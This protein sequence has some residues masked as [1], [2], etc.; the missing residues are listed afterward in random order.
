MRVTVIGAGSWGTALAIHLC[1]RADHTVTLL[2]FDSPAAAAAADAARCNAAYHA[3]TP[4]PPALAVAHLS[5]AALAAAAPELLLLAVPSCALREVLQGLAPA[6]PPGA[7]LVC[8]AKGLEEAPCGALLTMH[9]VA[10]S[11]LPAALLAS[12]C[13][14]GGPSF[15]AEVAAGQPT[16]VVV[17]SHCPAA[18]AAAAAALHCGLFR[19][20]TSADVPGV[21]LGGALKNV[22]AIACGVSDGAGLGANARA[23]LITRG[24]GEVTQIAVARGAQ[25]LTLLGLSGVGDLIL[26]C[27]SPLSRN[28]RVG[29]ALGQGRALPAVLLELG[30][31]AEGVGTAR[32]AWRLA[33][34]LR[35]AAPLIGH[36]HAML[37][38]GR[39]FKDVLAAIAAEGAPRA[40]WGGSLGAAADAAAAAA[41]AGA[42]G[43]SGGAASAP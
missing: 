19:C 25:P 41:E 14:L 37:H 36:V 15:A 5:P 21:E 7:I 29:L 3:S 12:F 40:E 8:A 11:V 31:V 26:T 24:L 27:T 4:L 9:G 18:A 30:Q 39:A 28:Y 13:A 22:I 35:I 6:I 43:G 1:R 2:G 10:A 33:Q 42:G 16:A 23:A 34:A 17:A 32:V 20:Y 38:E